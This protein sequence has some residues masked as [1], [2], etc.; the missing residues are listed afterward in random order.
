MTGKAASR[1]PRTASLCTADTQAMPV[2]RPLYAINDLGRHEETTGVLAGGRP[3][4][5]VE[6]EDQFR[7]PYE[8]IV[9]EP[10]DRRLDSLLPRQEL[11]DL[12]AERVASRI[13]EIVIEKRADLRRRGDQSA[14]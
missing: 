11:S 1:R 5:R 3:V 12:G 9:G 4:V 7:K 2:D 8:L 10:S 13:P 14:A 6:I